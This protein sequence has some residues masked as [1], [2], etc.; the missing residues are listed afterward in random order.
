VVVIFTLITISA[1]GDGGCGCYFVPHHQRDCVYVK[2]VVVVVIF[3][4]TPSSARLSVC[5]GGG[6]GRNLRPLPHP[7]HDLV[8]VK[9]VVVVVNLPASSAR[10]AIDEG[11]RGV[12]LYTLIVILPS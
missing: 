2:E 10:L 8:Y 12:Y 4:L 11:G 7:Q 6:C 9:V 3:A 1:T 5:E